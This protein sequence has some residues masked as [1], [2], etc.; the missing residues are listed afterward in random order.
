MILII[1]EQK[2]CYSSLV[3]SCGLFSVSH[4]NLPA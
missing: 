2:F 4:E 1:V 3:H